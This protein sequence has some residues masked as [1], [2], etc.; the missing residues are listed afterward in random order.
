MGG[1]QFTQEALAKHAKVCKKVFVEKRKAFNSIAA[2]LDGFEDAQ[3]LISKARREEMK[4][5]RGIKEVKKGTKSWRLKSEQFRNA[6]SV[7][8][9]T[10]GADPD[11]AA[12]LAALEAQDESKVVCPHCGRRFNEDS[13]KR[14]I[15]ICQKTFGTKADGG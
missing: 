14:H 12:R 11:A 3:E 13:G 8:R 15:A 10:D 6:I 1:R 9:D 4:R 5:E 7:A 2:W